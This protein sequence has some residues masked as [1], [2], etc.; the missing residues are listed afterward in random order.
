MIKIGTIFDNEFSRYGVIMS[1]IDFKP[2][3]DKLQNCFCPDDSVYYTPSW[4]ELEK[5]D[6][7]KVI[8][9]KIFGGMDIQIGVCSGRNTALNCLEY[10]RSEELNIYA[11]DAIVLLAKRDEIKDRRI[12]SSNVRAFFVP[13]GSGLIFYSS[14][15]HF[16]PCQTEQA[17]SFRVAVVLPKGTNEQK[18][19]IIP[20]SGEDS[21]LWGK[22][23]WLMAHPEAAEASQGAFVGITGPNI[24]LWN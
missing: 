3:I 9:N 23:K 24:R 14:T 20:E 4:D 1:G 2:V 5:T 16:A 18:P 13:S 8:Q 17:E 12:D 19:D 22:N 10:H 6:I 21:L 15:L 11:T 7:A